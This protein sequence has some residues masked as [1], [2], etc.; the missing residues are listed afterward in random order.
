MKNKVIKACSSLSNILFTKFWCHNLDCSSKNKNKFMK[1]DWFLLIHL[2]IQHTCPLSVAGHNE[3]QNPRKMQINVYLR[4]RV[5]TTKRCVV[6][7]AHKMVHTPLG[8]RDLPGSNIRLKSWQLHSNSSI[9]RSAGPAFCTE[10]LY[11]PK[12]NQDIIRRDRLAI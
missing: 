6:I 11:T 2:S 12:L 7:W 5:I 1:F 8:M 3:K 4:Y 9:G 10:S